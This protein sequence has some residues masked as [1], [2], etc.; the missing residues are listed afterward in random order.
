MALGR[1]H[2]EKNGLRS[3][4]ITRRMAL[5]QVHYEKNGLRLSTL[6][7]EWP[8]LEGGVEWEPT[9][10]NALDWGPY[11]EPVQ[12]CLIDEIIQEIT[13]RIIYDK[14]KKPGK[15]IM[16]KKGDRLPSR[17]MEFFLL[18]W[19]KEPFVKMEGM[20]HRCHFSEL[21]FHFRM[22]HRN[23]LVNFWQGFFYCCGGSGGGERGVKEEGM[24]LQIST[25]A[26]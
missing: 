16:E 2:Y 23:T 26:S 15:I 9:S 7:E 18:R 3:S 5:G 1:A 4:R 20:W 8:L 17:K 10:G 21:K 6:R 11:K 22:C 25:R 19:K 12:N 13:R 24:Y 14:A